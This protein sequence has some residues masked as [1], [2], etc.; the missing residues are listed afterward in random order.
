MERLFC[1]LGSRKCAPTDGHEA[2]AHPINLG[3]GAARRLSDR[4]NWTQIW[5]KTSF[6]LFPVSKNTR[7][8]LQGE[9]STSISYLQVTLSTLI[10]DWAVQW[11]VGQQELH[12]PLPDDKHTAGR[13]TITNYTTAGAFLIQI[14]EL[15]LTWLYV[16]FPSWWGCSIPS[17]Q[18]WR[19]LPLASEWQHTQTN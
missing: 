4:T 5:P 8:G 9:P 17:W 10:T 11:V 18:A 7:F 14:R 15:N 19:K 3:S 13:F 12:H 16:S 1:R 6:S 2:W